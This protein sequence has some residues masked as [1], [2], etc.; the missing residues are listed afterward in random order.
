LV[1]S[2]SVLVLNAKGGEIK[3]KA[4]GSATICELFKILV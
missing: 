3:A 1:I 2:S 4:T